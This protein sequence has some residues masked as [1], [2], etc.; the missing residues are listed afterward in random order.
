MWSGVGQ[1]RMARFGFDQPNSL[2]GFFCFVGFFALVSFVHFCFDPDLDLLL[3]EV[4][5]KGW[6]LTFQIFQRM[7]FHGDDGGFWH[8]F[9]EQSFGENSHK[10]IGPIVFGVLLLMMTVVFGIRVDGVNA[11]LHFPGIGDAAFVGC[12][13][14]IQFPGKGIQIVRDTWSLFNRVFVGLVPPREN[15]PVLEIVDILVVLVP[16]VCLDQVLGLQIQGFEK[17]VAPQVCAHMWPGV[18][19]HDFLW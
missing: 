5:A 18:D 12:Q 1:N 8:V 7:A 13:Q 3:E 15:F 16:G 4:L 9:L 19:V 14:R 6:I 2:I 10:G 11:E 17:V